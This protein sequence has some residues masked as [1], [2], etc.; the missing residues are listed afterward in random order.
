MMYYYLRFVL[1]LHS[2]V[3]NV[4]SILS[5][6]WYQGNYPLV[7][8]LVLLTYHLKR[9]EPENII[10]RV[11][12]NSGLSLRILEGADIPMA[13]LENQNVINFDNKGQLNKRTLKGHAL[14]VHTKYDDC[15]ADHE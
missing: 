10:L 12:E 15:G 7:I 14:C 4:S 9:E 13:D 8:T 6:R 3:S 1:T 5:N 11:W 2:K